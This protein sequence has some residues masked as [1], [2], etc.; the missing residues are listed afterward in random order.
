M[1]DPRNRS[2]SDV[3]TLAKQAQLEKAKHRL[4][5]NLA[6]ESRAVEAASSYLQDTYLGDVDRQLQRDAVAAERYN[7]A[8]Q[9]FIPPV[10]SEWLGTAIPGAYEMSRTK[11][12][13]VHDGWDTSKLGKVFGAGKADTPLG[14]AVTLLGALTDGSV[15]TVGGVLGAVDGLKLAQAG[16]ALTDDDIELHLKVATGQA[17]PEEIARY[18]K[19]SDNGLWHL[20]TGTFNPSIKDLINAHAQS[21][22]NLDKRQESIDKLK[23]GTS[24]PSAKLS[25]GITDIL[26]SDASAMDKAMGILGEFG[27]NKLGAMALIA[28]NLPQVFPYLISAPLGAAITAADSMGTSGMRAVEGI[29]A[30]TA[31]GE[32]LTGNDARDLAT[33]QYGHALANTLGGLITGGVAAAGSKAAGSL[34]S[35]S[36]IPSIGKGLGGLAASGLGEAATGATQEALEQ[37]MKGEELDAAEIGTSAILEAFAGVGVPVVTTAAEA[38]GQATNDAVLS[39]LANLLEPNAST[40]DSTADAPS[41]PSAEPSTAPTEP[42]QEDTPTNVPEAAEE[43]SQA[44]YELP[45]N[46]PTEDEIA[47]GDISA[48]SD[49]TTTSYNPTKAANIL[50][51]NAAREGKDLSELVEDIDQLYTGAQNRKELL[52]KR[53]VGFEPESLEK[54]TDNLVKVKE[55]LAQDPSNQKLKELEGAL[56]AQYSNFSNPENKATI[57][58]MISEAEMHADELQAI[59]QDISSTAPTTDTGTTDAAN[60]EIGITTTETP[61]SG[62]PMTPDMDSSESETTTTTEPSIPETDVTEDVELSI[63][64]SDIAPAPNTPALPKASVEATKKIES[65]M[66]AGDF[67]STRTAVNDAV[68]VASN[69]QSTMSTYDNLK[70]KAVETGQEIR[71]TVSNLGNVTPDPNGEVVITPVAVEVAPIRQTAET[72]YTEAKALEQEGRSKLITPAT[73]QG[74]PMVSPYSA[75]IKEGRSTVVPDVAQDAVVSEISSVEDT[76]QTT[77]D[78]LANAADNLSYTSS[79]ERITGLIDRAISNGFYDIAVEISDKYTAPIDADNIPSE[80]LPA[81]AKNQE[82]VGQH[83]ENAMASVDPSTR[84]EGA[85]DADLGVQ[86]GSHETGY[87]NSTIGAFRAPVN[88]SNVVRKGMTQVSN[89]SKPLT[90]VSNFLTTLRKGGTKVSNYLPKDFFKDKKPEAVQKSQAAIRD[91]IQFANAF[92]EAIYGTFRTDAS[93]DNP[94]AYRDPIQYLLVDST[95]LDGNTR[96]HL[97]ENVVTAAGIAG[98]LSTYEGVSSG[99]KTKEEVVEMLGLDK[100]AK[101][102]LPSDLY[103]AMKG[104]EMSPSVFAND[105]GR[106]ALDMLGLR[107]NK[108]GSFTG[109]ENKL[110]SSIGNTALRGMVEMGAVEVVTVNPKDYGVDASPRT[111]LKFPKDSNGKTSNIAGRIKSLNEG[112][113]YAVSKL[114]TGEIPVSAPTTKPQKVSK[115]IDNMGRTVPDNMLK[116]L[117][118][119]NNR[120][121]KVKLNNLKVFKT[122]DRSILESIVGIDQ[123]PLEHIH[124]DLRDAVIAKN[125][126]LTKQIDEGL[127]TIEDMGE[128]SDYF[129]LNEAWSQQRVGLSSSVLNPLFH[130]QVGRVLMGAQGIEQ[131]YSLTSESDLDTFYHSL[132]EAFGLKAEN[133]KAEAVRAFI[134]STLQQAPFVEAVDAL[135][136]LLDPGTTSLSVDQQ[137]AVKEAVALMRENSMSLDALNAVAAMKKAQ[138]SG[139]SVFVSNFLGSVDGKSSGQILSKI[140]M[141]VLSVEEATAVLDAGGFFTDENIKDFADF[142]AGEKGQD[143]YE[144]VVAGVLKAVAAFQGMRAAAVKGSKSNN[145]EVRKSSQETLKNIKT[146]PEGAALLWKFLGNPVDQETGKVTG[147]GRNLVKTATLA[148]SFGAGANTATSSLK[149]Q[150]IDSVYAALEK[151][152]QAGKLGAVR[153]IIKDLNTLVNLHSRKNVKNPFGN[154]EAY[155]LENALEIPFTVPALEALGRAVS[156]ELGTPMASYLELANETFTRSSKALADSS[157]LMHFLYAEVLN[158]AINTAT[159][160]YVNSPEGAGMKTRVG[161][162]FGLPQEVLESVKEGIK[163]LMP[164]IGSAYSAESSE[165]TGGLLASKVSSD[166]DP[167]TTVESQYVGKD[168][169]NKTITTHPAST[170]PTAPGPALIGT[171]THSLDGKIITKALAEFGGTSGHDA[172]MG[173]GKKLQTVGKSLNR[174][175]YLELAKYN[176]LLETVKGLVRQLDYLA[177]ANVSDTV[178][179]NAL[180]NFA[181]SEADK[182]T[183]KDFSETIQSLVNAARA[184]ENGKLKFLNEVNTVS[185]YAMGGASY[186]V[187]PSDKAE[188]RKLIENMDERLAPLDELLNHPYMAELIRASEASS[189]IPAKESVAPS[190]ALIEED[191]TSVEAPNA[192]ALET[193]SEGFLA[194]TGASYVREAIAGIKAVLGAHIPTDVINALNKLN[195]ESGESIASQLKRAKVLKPTFNKIANALS[196]FVDSNPATKPN[197]LG[198]PVVPSNP[199]IEAFLAQHGTIPVRGVIAHLLALNKGKAENVP[200]FRLLQMAAQIV[201]PNTLVEYV[202]PLRA[203]EIGLPGVLSDTSNALG[204]F[205]TNGSSQRI[206]VRSSDFVHSGITSEL[207]THEIIHAALAGI[208]ENALQ[209]EKHPARKEVTELVNLLEHIKKNANPASV[210]RFSEALANPHE[211]LAW[212]L[213]NSSF[214]QFLQ[215]VE[216]PRNEPNPRVRNLSQKFLDIISNIFM[217]AFANR[218]WGNKEASGVY[219]AFDSLL[220]SSSDLFGLAREARSNNQDAIL[221]PKDKALTLFKKQEGILE[222]AEKLDTGNISQKHLNSLREVLSDLDHKA[223]G[224]FNSG[225]QEASEGLTEVDATKAATLTIPM[226][227]VEQFAKEMVF[228]TAT[229]GISQSPALRSSSDFKATAAYMRHVAQ[230]APADFKNSPAFMELL[231]LDAKGKALSPA[232]KIANFL[233]LATTSE[234]I[235]GVLN[236]TPLPNVGAA[237]GPM[238]QK[239]LDT[240]S[241]ALDYVFDEY[242]RGMATEPTEALK[243]FSGRIAGTLQN[244]EESIMGKALS[245]TDSL[246]DSWDSLLGDSKALISN[247][248]SKLNPSS[249]GGIF[250]KNA[251]T[252]LDGLLQGETE[253][254]TKA[255]GNFRDRL[256]NKKNGL[257][258]STGKYISGYGQHLTSLMQATKHIEKRKEIQS[259]TVARVVMAGFKDGGSYLTPESKKAITDNFLRTD[260]SSLLGQYTDQDIIRLVSDP[261]YLKQEM[262]KARTAVAEAFKGTPLIPQYIS[263]ANA[264]GNFMATGETN[265]PNLPLSATGIASGWM[266]GLKN[267]PTKAQ[268]QAIDAL[269]TMEAI[270]VTPKGDI[271][272]VIST[273]ASKADGDSGLAILL[274]IHKHVEDS[275]PFDDWE[276]GLKVKGYTPFIGN[277]DTEMTFVDSAEVSDYELAGYVVVGD[278]HYD[279]TASVKPQSSKVMMT[280]KHGRTHDRVSGVLPLISNHAKGTSVDTYTSNQLRTLSIRNANSARAYRY[281]GNMA[282]GRKAIPLYDSEGRITDYRYTMS[283]YAADSVLERNSDFDHLLG[284]MAGNSLDK[285]LSK[286]QA[287]MLVEELKKDWEE[288]GEKEPHSFITLSAHAPIEEHKEMYFMLPVAVRSANKTIRIRKDEVD[289]ILGYKKFTMADSFLKD[290]SERNALERIL[291]GGL[292]HVYAAYGKHL[293]GHS[294]AQAQQFAKRLAP[295]IVK[296]G[297][298]VKELAAEMK[299]W[300][301]IKSG[302]V[303]AANLYSN[304]TLLKIQG[305][306]VKD[307]FRLQAEGLKAIRELKKIETEIATIQVELASELNRNNGVH[308]ASTIDKANKLQLLKDALENNPTKYLYDLGMISTVAEDLQQNVDPFSFKNSLSEKIQ[309]KLDTL[310]GAVSEVAKTLYM[311][312]D[313]PAYKFM[314]EATQY[315]DFVARYAL[316]EHLTKRDKNPLS[317]EEAIHEINE[318]FVVYDIPLPKG[319]QYL[320]DLYIL[321]FSK[322]FLS[323]QRVLFRQLRDRPVSTLSTVMLSDYIG[324]ADS[325]QDTNILGRLGNNP[326]WGSVAEAPELFG[327]IM[328]IKGLM[329]VMK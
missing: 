66:A 101:S 128:T 70:K 81:I 213:T 194:G 57:E 306:G 102:T 26:N 42:G 25:K 219:T 114:F 67:E 299:D 159:E 148:V 255:M 94:Y 173:G 53:L 108:A 118:K 252:V 301:V 275:A 145:A 206:Y 317:N 96:K 6:L 198:E 287:E 91:S 235:Q 86:R 286:A 268:I 170:I 207:L 33:Q 316:Y 58:R 212:G 82:I 223:T 76:R 277:P 302:F 1:T 31:K 129:F 4:T 176:P 146:S 20:S 64:E 123:R 285:Q 24:A 72:T 293:K 244:K 249:K 250:V 209:N 309:G 284:R 47:A 62:I 243:R 171:S 137:N 56:T 115:V 224:P 100:G 217:K 51:F 79:P 83:Y 292:E 227:E 21:Q 111:Y 234:H 321:P 133:M 270:R 60:T 304:T 63:S 253:V 218:P 187:T 18:E 262:D 166:T 190:E 2:L 192:K 256:Y 290:P 103:G 220:E 12:V 43:P 161:S 130:K 9:G 291:V 295:I 258:A 210:A 160:E 307:I 247:S 141:G 260:A 233:A 68:T 153:T 85:T 158:D 75:T 319:L 240:V 149:E 49:E 172:W 13:S 36:A 119:I 88:D 197:L 32:P 59:K 99:F 191:G 328:P 157:N 232:E 151:A 269:A 174:S 229:E 164:F 248:I 117:Q 77:Y 113:G 3:L 152:V 112:T 216:A 236:R 276:T 226:S 322:Y 278:T 188:I 132:G 303:F 154:P 39:T 23:V 156:N 22:E 121:Y 259:D 74:K 73:G 215:S 95:G 273:E 225:L 138:D 34:V 241:E 38:T 230:H 237:K 109:L 308:T 14:A 297:K 263:Y 16:G 181:N 30:R 283:F 186:T 211:L 320:D 37:T 222:K 327:D 288:N 298:G 41:D 214:M 80:D 196:T 165:Y 179:A 242:T 175:A 19:P 183:I 314:F 78:A 300:I 167:T 93:P 266:L 318:A 122:L 125:S 169:K 107:P 324:L 184:T 46:T 163:P 271:A 162:K 84:V 185:Q 281:S 10:D 329:T 147:N 116:D 204:W 48:Y 239:L 144:R 55:A 126:Q 189:T 155:T 106:R 195:T 208:V 289:V 228:H 251:V 221:W 69:A 61:E 8:S 326:F 45:E 279:P 134:E 265:A 267:A 238:Q 305:M 142:M 177:D 325:V 264:L 110:A 5:P 200:Y 15:R 35:G 312:K 282:T 168:G 131:T 202:T 182:G 104:L 28:E 92:E 201:D 143:Y 52:E 254:L 274:G 65:E 44:F 27:D 11:G 29:D 315:S 323:I 97:D 257:L 310:P 294:D 136:S 199:D 296:G 205:E 7:K 54:I 50:V 135:T 261:A 71:A 120:P 40:E 17:T 272:S 193:A 246:E 98:Y 127:A 203:N 180:N 90:A 89:P 280:R 313:T 150:T 87:A 311:S 245:V 139:E 124:V 105:I 231:A 140:L 178:L